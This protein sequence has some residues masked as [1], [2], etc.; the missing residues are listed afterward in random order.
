M[1]M[2]KEYSIETEIGQKVWQIRINLPFDGKGDFLYKHGIFI[3]ELSIIYQTNYKI[4]LSNDW[5]TCLD[6]KEKGKKKESYQT[7]LDDLK[8]SVKTKETYFPN[9]IFAIIYSTKEPTEAL[10]N[11]FKKEIKQQVEKEYSFLYNIDELL[12]NLV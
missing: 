11:S 4:A 9:G 12:N 2:N 6:R 8:I 10:L 1:K 5:I 7:Y 3:E